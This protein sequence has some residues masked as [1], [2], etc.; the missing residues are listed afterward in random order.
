MTTETHGPTDD[1]L[2]EVASADAGVGWCRACG[3]ERVSVELDARGL[4]VRVVR[5][6]GG[7]YDGKTETTVLCTG[8]RFIVY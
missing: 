7:S 4:H 1:R 2:R 5:S 3:V 8:D 6:A